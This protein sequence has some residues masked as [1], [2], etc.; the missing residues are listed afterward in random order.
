[1]VEKNVHDHNRALC[2]GHAYNHG[3]KMELNIA[4]SAGSSM[5][6]KRRGDEGCGV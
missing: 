5:N 6:R 3:K 1:V 4:W 2:L